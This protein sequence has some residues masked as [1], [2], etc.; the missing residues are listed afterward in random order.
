MSQCQH[1]IRLAEGWRAKAETIR[2]KYAKQ[3]PNTVA[4]VVV[5]LETCAEELEEGLRR[6]P[7][8][9]PSD[10]LQGAGSKPANLQPST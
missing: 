1:L 2:R 4:H 10:K 3:S 9:V 8:A 6:A 7:V 5:A